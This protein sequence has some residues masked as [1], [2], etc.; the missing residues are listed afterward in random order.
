MNSTSFQASLNWIKRRT[1][2]M[3]TFKCIVLTWKRWKETFQD[4]LLLRIQDWVINSFLDARS[5]ETGVAEEKIV[6]LQN[7]IELRPMFKKSY[8]DFW[9][10]KK[11]SDFYPVLWNKVKIYFILL[12]FQ[13]LIW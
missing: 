11:I 1:Y 9:L 5:E 12:P 4:I 8:Q 3:I 10:L 6:S 2:Q 13:N 7:D